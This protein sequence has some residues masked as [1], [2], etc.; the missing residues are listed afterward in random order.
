MLPILALLVLGLVLRLW[1]LEV[2]SRDGYRWDHFDNISMGLGARNHGLLNI[3]T[4]DKKDVALV[5]GQIYHNGQFVEHVRR[6]I[7]APNYP[8]L[9][10]AMF[11]VQTG[12]LPEPIKANTFAAR[13][14]MASAPML[15]EFLTALGAALIA[16]QVFGKKVGYWAGALCWLCP[17][18]ILNTAFF[19]QI[20][21]LVLAPSVFMVWLMLKRKWVFAGACLAIACLLKPAYLMH[22]IYFLFWRRSMSTGQS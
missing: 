12:L 2:G 7:F 10:L 6:P 4:I 3:Y 21:S 13:L 11:W 1:L 15:A 20:D 16:W 18:I 9:T 22:G 19:V 17:P 5:P 8:P 14:I